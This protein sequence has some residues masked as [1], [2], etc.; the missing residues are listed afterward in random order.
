MLA[1]ATGTLPEP[2]LQGDVGVH[3]FWAAGT[4]AI[5]DVRVT[6]TNAPSQH[7]VDPANILNKHERAKKAKY[8]DLCLARR[9]TFTP[10]VFSVDGLLGVEASAAMKRLATLLTG[11]WHQPYSQVTGYVRSRLPVALARSKSRCLRADRSPPARNP[12]PAWES[13]AG[14]GLYR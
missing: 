12:E 7:N 2:D 13:G 1:R 8:N 6:D 9:R 5:F 4:Q 10:L 11:K 3:G 14:L